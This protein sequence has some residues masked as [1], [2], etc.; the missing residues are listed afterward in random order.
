MQI[1]KIQ[2]SYRKSNP[3]I[4]FLPNI[5]LIITTVTTIMVVKNYQKFKITSRIVSSNYK[6]CIRSCRYVEKHHIKSVIIAV[7]TVKLCWTRSKSYTHL[8]IGIEPRTIRM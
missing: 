6:K 4:A 5:F 3:N 8:S 2:R 7:I 1:E